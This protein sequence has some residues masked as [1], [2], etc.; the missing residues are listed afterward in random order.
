MSKLIFV[1]INN[2]EWLFNG[3]LTASGHKTCH[4]CQAKSHANLLSSVFEERSPH[5]TFVV[6]L[7]FTYHLFTRVGLSIHSL[8]RCYSFKCRVSRCLKNYLTFKRI[9][10]SKLDEILLAANRELCEKY[11]GKKSPRCHL[12]W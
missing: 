8:G 12:S 9:S 2:F 11:T 4:L 7:G 1:I 10:S 6:S 5:Y 3:I